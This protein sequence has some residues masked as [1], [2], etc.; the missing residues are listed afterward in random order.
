MPMNAV[1]EAVEVL[2]LSI[3]YPSPRRFGRHVL[4]SGENIVVRVRDSDGRVGLGESI[5]RP[6]VYGES[7]KSIV[8]AI[9]EWFG[10]AVMGR[11]ILDI[12]DMWRTWDGVA[13]NFAAKAGLD[14]AIHDLQAQ[15]VGLPLWRWLGGTSQ[16]IPL[17]W[18]LTY[19]TSAAVCEEAVRRWSEGYSCFKVKISNDRAHDRDMLQRIRSE[20]PETA[21][22]YADANG[23]LTRAEFLRRIP[24]L[25]EY[26]VESVEDPL[27]PGYMESRHSL[28][29]ATQ[30]PILADETAK[31]PEEAANE[32]MSGAVDLFSLKIFRTGIS[33]SRD[34]ARI[35][36]AFGRDC[37]VGGQGET[38]V[39][40]AIAAHFASSLYAMGFDHYP[41]EVSSSYRFDFDTTHGGQQLIAGSLHLSDA[42]GSGIVLNEEV[43]A[44]L[45]S[46]EEFGYVRRDGWC[47]G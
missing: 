17:T 6:Y 5:P 13:A 26:G 43:L 12:D 41:A 7:A 33:R 44:K 22:L 3:P 30:M 10:P 47:S 27:I 35:A 28:G 15:A 11:P 8:H 40:A 18:I 23:S 14:M 2:P 16:T 38:Q 1:V 31:S 24:E 45:S 36:R 19:G 21:R 9:I 20:L 4:T 25:I 39:G 37:L 29:S 32:I 46:A 42:A 34:I